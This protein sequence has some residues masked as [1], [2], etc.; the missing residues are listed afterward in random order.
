MV[1][2]REA[3][4]G[5]ND[6]D[7]DARLFHQSNACAICRRKFSETLHY[8]VDHCHRDGRVRGLLCGHCNT[9]I[10]RMH[11]NRGWMENAASYLQGWGE[12]T[13]NQFVPGSPGAEGAPLP[14][15]CSRHNIEGDTCRYCTAESG[16]KD[17]TEWT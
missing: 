17:H 13:Q 9:E 15:Y 3:L 11:E 4:Y 16:A 7:I 8:C 2:R 12:S 14:E 5:L 1:A 6:A 10:G